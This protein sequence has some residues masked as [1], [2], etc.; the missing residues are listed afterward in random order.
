M[1]D[2]D[3]ERRQHRAQQL[4]EEA[5]EILKRA[6]YIADDDRP[7]RAARLVERARIKQRAADD[8]EGRSP[9]GGDRRLPASPK[10]PAQSDGL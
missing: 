1:S 8:L 6:A 5:G 10:L 2:R 9:H 3:A 4:R 7:A